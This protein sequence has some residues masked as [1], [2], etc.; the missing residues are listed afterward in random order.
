MG[1]RD[2][3][4]PDD[5]ERAFAQCP[6]IA[7]LRGLD[8]SKAIE[9]GDALVDA[10]FTLIEVP[11]NSPEP[12]RSIAALAKRHGA[13]VLVGAGTVL[14]VR[15][16]EAVRV[17][18]GRLIVSPNT[19]TSVI[20]ATAAAGL[21]SLPGYAT[22][23]EGLDAVSAGGHALKLFPAEASSPSVLRAHLTVLPPGMRVLVVGGVSAGTMKPW[24]EAGAAGFGLGSALYQKHK[25]LKDIAETARQFVSVFRELRG[26]VKALY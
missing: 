11:L 3:N 12:L 4:G 19:D 1:V 22:P 6:L 5:F 18:G 10:G 15:D 25:A 8:P 20:R 2:V 17:A 9:V 16:V 13:R 21:A 7:I 23:T 26:I 14:T 24:V